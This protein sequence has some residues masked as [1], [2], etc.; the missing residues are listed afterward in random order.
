MRRNSKSANGLYCFHNRK[1]LVFV[2]LLFM[3]ILIFSCLLSEFKG[4]SPFV[5]GASDVVVSNETEL[6]NAIDNASSKETIIALDKD[7]VLTGPIV[8]SANKD[9]KLVS[10]KVFGFYKL[11]SAPVC[12]VIF[13]EKAGVLKIDGVIVTREKDTNGEGVLIG[14]GGTFIL[15]SGEVF[16]H[17]AIGS[18]EMNVLNHGA[19]VT[20]YGVFEMHGGKIFGNTAK[21]SNGGGV[22]NSGVFM[23]FGGEISDNVAHSRF[24][25]THGGGVCNKGTFRM[26]GGKIS[27]NTAT[28]GGGVFNSGTF[29]MSGGVISGNTA[30]QGSGVYYD[31]DSGTFEWLD[32]VISGNTSTGNYDDNV[33]P[34]ISDNGSSGNNNGGGSSNNN[35]S[36]NG[37]NNSSDGNGDDGFNVWIFV[38]IVVVVL[39]LVV[40]G[41]MFV[42]FKKK[43]ARI[44]AKFNPLL[45]GR[46]EE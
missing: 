32:G 21:E 39:S 13:V 22:L 41:C 6:K 42:Y 45:Q 4:V 40:V 38:V 25:S 36:N 35:G 37:N 31:L 44:E 30:G 46:V 28:F 11:I 29:T 10:N 14:S 1:T 16:G 26:S 3:I 2:S 17:T 12:Q 43:V 34:P 9:I 33:Y 19:G 5:L 27:G 18:S 20:N 7:I 23:M 8:I 24:G 15:Y